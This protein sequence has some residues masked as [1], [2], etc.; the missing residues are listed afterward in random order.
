VPL[1][2][3]MDD[4]QTANVREL[5]AAGGARAIAQSDFTP[6]NLAKQ[7]QKLGLEPDALANAARRAWGVGRPD[8][9]ERLADLVER[10]AA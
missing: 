1:P 4:H 2:S 9:A 3:A 7:M 8:A 5:V 6:V 10:L